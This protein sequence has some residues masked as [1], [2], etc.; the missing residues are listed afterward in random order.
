M[1]SSLDD[2]QRIW[3]SVG[4]GMVGFFLM[5]VGGGLL[6]NLFGYSHLFW[7]GVVLQL[8]SMGFFYAN[9]LSRPHFT[10]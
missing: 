10:D 6:P 9:L 5:F 7:S 4:F 3:I 8:G 2:T 1:I